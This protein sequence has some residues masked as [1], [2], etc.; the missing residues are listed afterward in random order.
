MGT[1]NIDVTLSTDDLADS[2]V[3]WKVIIDVTDSDHRLIT[4]DVSADREEENRDPR[5]ELRFDVTKADWDSFRHQ[6]T[7]SLAKDYREGSIEETALSLVNSLV[8]AAK[9]SIPL[10]GKSRRKKLPSWWSPE[11]TAKKEKKPGQ[12]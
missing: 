8:K 11:L 5:D 4:F 7:V 9:S 1:S 2:V 12:L 6:I 3:N 10:K